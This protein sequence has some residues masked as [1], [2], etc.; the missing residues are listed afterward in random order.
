MLPDHRTPAVSGYTEDRP[1]GVIFDGQHSSYVTGDAPG[2]AGGWKEARRFLC[3]AS[4]DVPRP[5]GR[6]S[7]ALGRVE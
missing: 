5:D 7:G 2:R 1:A 6:L 3:L 4:V